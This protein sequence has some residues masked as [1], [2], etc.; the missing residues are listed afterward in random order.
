MAE[1][2][3]EL[4]MP[5]KN[6]PAYM[7]QEPFP[8][9]G[10]APLL[11]SVG[12]IVYHWNTLERTLRTILVE[13]AGLVDPIKGTTPAATILTANL[14][15]ANLI[16]AL[17]T[18]AA[19]C[20][21]GDYQLH[22]AHLA[23]LADRCREYRNAYVHDFNGVQVRV[24]QATKGKEKSLYVE[25]GPGIL[26]YTSIRS[27]VRKYETYVD[28]Q[29]AKSVGLMLQGACEYAALVTLALRSNRNA[30]EV[31]KLHTLPEKF[32]LPYRVSRTPLGP[33]G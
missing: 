20:L 21:V 16:M 31:A 4:Q 10:W 22:V 33:A 24:M 32:P 25:P 2:K 14:Q 15:A 26:Q 19:E 8:S 27:A 13:E 12:R 1:E 6:T 9:E 30:A 28:I 17:R 11:V 23:D 7:L 18:L 5:D 29:D 3:P